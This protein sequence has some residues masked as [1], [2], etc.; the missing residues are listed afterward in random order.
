MFDTKLARSAK[1]EALLQPAAYADQLRS[2]GVPVHR[3][4]HL[5]PGTN[6]TTS[7]PLPES[8]PLFFAARDRLR[9]V[10]EAHRRGSLPSSWGDPRW[11]ACLKCPDCKAEMEAADDLML[12]R[13]M[14]KSRRAK[15]IEAGIRT[16]VLSSCD[17]LSPCESCETVS[18]YGSTR[19]KSTRAARHL[20][21][22]FF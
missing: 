8:I 22:G 20:A 12:V 10:L 11:L 15:L 19:R 1:A 21:A 4:G 9:A 18:R 2:A 3:E 16:T 14:N 5:I 17:W 7:H 13:R 6:E